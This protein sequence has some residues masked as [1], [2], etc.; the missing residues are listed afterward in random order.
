MTISEESPVKKTLVGKAN[1]FI[2][3]LINQ[4]SDQ[5]TIS[6]PCQLGSPRSLALQRNELEKEYIQENSQITVVIQQKEFELQSLTEAE[7]E[8]D[9]RHVLKSEIKVLKDQATRLLDS[10]LK[11][12]QALDNEIGLKKDREMDEMDDVISKFKRIVVV[13]EPDSIKRTIKPARYFSDLQALIETYHPGFTVTLSVPGTSQVVG[14]QFELFCAYQDAEKD[15]LILNLKLSVIKKRAHDESEDEVDANFVR[16][17]G[18]WSNSEIQ[19]FQ[20][21]VEQ[22]GWGEW[23]KIASTIQTRDRGQV[24]TFSM[25]QRA[26][27]FKSSVSLNHA[28]TDL[29]ECFEVVARGFKVVARGL[30]ID[31]VNDED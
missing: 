13:L 3:Q 22:Y 18:K 21:G 4:P 28:L 24:R 5:T 11:A 8:N 25:N 9:K 17:A 19:L 10:K 2:Q 14:S 31:E 1:S 16:H 6:Q 20:A 12:A 7:D 30:K 15:V 23:A 27:K 29:A 26:K